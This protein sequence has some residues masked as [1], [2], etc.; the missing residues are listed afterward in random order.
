MEILIPIISGVV[1]GFTAGLFGVGGGVIAVPILFFTLERLAVS[2]DTLAQQVIF[3]SLAIVVCTTAVSAISHWRR[4]ATKMPHFIRMSSGLVLGSILGTTTLI[5]V[6]SQTIKILLGI[7]F[8][9]M[10]YVFS[11]KNNPLG[12]V[13]KKINKVPLILM[14]GFVG[15]VSVLFGIG[16]GVMNVAILHGHGL[17]MKHAIGSSAACGLVISLT[18]VIMSMIISL[19]GGEVLWQYIHLP[20]FVIISIV[21]GFFSTLGA[22]AAHAIDDKKLRKLFSLY[23]FMVALYFLIINLILPLLQQTL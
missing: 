17:S 20:S 14:G 18:A 16:G 10:A 3:T 5:S 2:E 13:T 7:F 4:N 22:R 23:L 6:N 21:A 1:I 15:W 9:I 8:L 11:T 19:Y 12:I